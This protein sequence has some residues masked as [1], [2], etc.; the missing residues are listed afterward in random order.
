VP[1]QARS[2]ASNHTTNLE[3]GEDHYRDQHRPAETETQ[4]TKGHCREGTRM[5]STNAA[6]RGGAL[7]NNHCQPPR[8][9]IR[10]TILTRLRGPRRPVTSPDRPQQRSPPPDQL[11]GLSRCVT[12]HSRQLAA[13]RLPI[14][15]RRPG[16]RA[17]W[18][19]VGLLVGGLACWRVQRWWVHILV[20][21]ALYVVLSVVGRL[22]LSLASRTGDVRGCLRG[23]AGSDVLDLGPAAA[24][25]CR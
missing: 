18:G 15:T 12:L 19:M 24:A 8:A 22:L 1:R 23:R 14:R 21:I 10:S 9:P 25:A 6:P 16:G 5:S 3:H 11:L 7:R 17:G 20:A 4:A 13:D 2:F